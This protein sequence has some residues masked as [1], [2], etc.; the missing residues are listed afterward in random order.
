VFSTVISCA[1]MWIR[2]LDEE[3][4]LRT[5]FGKKWEIYHHKTKR[6]IPGVV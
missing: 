3:E 6:F 1:V 2:V 5:A 4:L